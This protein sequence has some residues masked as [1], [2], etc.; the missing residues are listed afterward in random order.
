MIAPLA[1]SQLRGARVTVMGLGRFGGGLGVTKWLHAMGARVLVTDIKGPE[2]FTHELNDLR[3]LLERS[4]V[5]LR[6]G[7]HDERDFTE[8]DLVVANPA[9]PRPWENPY[10]SAS[11]RAGVRVTTE[12]ELMV[13]RLDR[14]RTIGVTGTVGKSTTTAMIACALRGAGVDARTGGNIGGSLLGEL[15]SS[16][17]ETW[18]VLELS[19][20]ML[21]WLGAAG[22]W[23]PRVSVVTGFS[24]N[25]LDWHASLDHYRASKMNIFAHADRTDTL[26][27]AP[28]VADWR[29]HAPQGAS[30][31]V[32]DPSS[33]TTPLRAPGEHNRANASLA[34]AAC[35]AAI[36]E[37]DE[38]RACTAL[39]TFTGLSHRLELVGEVRGVTFYNDSKCTTPEALATALSAVCSLPGVDPSR[40]HLIAGGYDKGASMEDVSR[41]GRELGGLYAIG[42]TGPRIARDAGARAVECGTLARAMVEVKSRARPGD[43]VLLSPACAS[44]DQYANYEARGEEF[45]TLAL[46]DA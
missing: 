2:Q 4:E 20:A 38:P 22:G 31:H 27:L 40:V 10:L 8:T 26:A 17:R 6:L 1:D 11:A 21:H 32:P 39:A 25:H 5:S 44:W 9:V 37:L 30:V 16:P 34:L 33:W 45:R 42:A 35:R 3:P 46:E 12:I 36:P 29:A 24:P 13:S 19:S 7:R 41:H 14:A 18:T 28:Q 15:N 23:S 43:V